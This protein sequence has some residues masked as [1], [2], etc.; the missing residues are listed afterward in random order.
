[1]IA[2]RTM[3]PMMNQGALSV[4]KSEAFSKTLLSLSAPLAC[5]VSALI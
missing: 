5:S 3:I 2:A 4:T 1:M